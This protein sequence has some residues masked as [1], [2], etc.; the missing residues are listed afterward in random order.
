LIPTHTLIITNPREDSGIMQI[1]PYP[2]AT[3]REDRRVFRISKKKQKRLFEVYLTS[4]ERMWEDA[5]KA[6]TP[7]A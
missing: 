2:Y 1:E 5:K 7:S 3:D 4:Y 6:I